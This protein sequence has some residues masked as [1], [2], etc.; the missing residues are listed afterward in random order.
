MSIE[1]ASQQA[2]ESKPDTAKPSRKPQLWRRPAVLIGGGVFL[3]AL[4]VVGVAWWLHGRKFEDTDDAFVDSHIVRLAPQTSGRLIHVFVNDNDRV[5][6]GDP[7]AEIDAAEARTR[8]D[9]TLAQQAQAETA[10]AQAQA[11]IG[12]AEAGEQQ[13]VSNLQVAAV[14]AERSARDLARYRELQAS[15][16]EAV[17]PEQL[18]QAATAARS[19]AAQREAAAKQ[20]KAASAQVT[21]ARAQLASARAKI[22]ELKA[23]VAQAQLTLGYTQVIAPIDGHIAQKAVEVGSYVTPGQEI[24]AI[25]PLQLWITAN[26]KETQ[27]A[28]MRVG[29]TVHVDVDACPQ[30]DLHGH[31]DSIQRGAGQAFGVLPPENATGNF[32]KVVQRVPVKIVLDALPQSCLLGPG[33]SAVPK[34]R[35]R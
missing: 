21:A 33:M 23:Q 35:V 7:I 26:F 9:Q 20:V 8:V 27:L 24:L 1:E 32:V 4:L 22:D 17:A 2:E 12:V 30:A 10:I 5:R 3:A 15:T 18:D 31:V 14:Q 34:V 16:P 19:A 29:Q 28:L 11:Q 25:V 6:S 13:A